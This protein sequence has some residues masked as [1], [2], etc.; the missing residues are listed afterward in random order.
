MRV[1]GNFQAVYDAARSFCFESYAGCPD[2]PVIVQLDGQWIL[3]DESHFE[4][5]PPIN[6]TLEVS[7]D[8]FTAWWYEFMVDPDFKPTEAA[9][10]EFA[11]LYCAENLAC[12]DVAD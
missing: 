12:L 10:G 9:I 2:H 6:Y 5:E 4:T 3:D 7:L 1:T 8:D 11:S